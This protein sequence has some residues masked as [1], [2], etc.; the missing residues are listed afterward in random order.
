MSPSRGP[1]AV[2]LLPERLVTVR[3][4][5]TRPFETYPGHAQ[6]T[7]LGCATPERIFLGLMEEI[8]G[9]I[10]DLLE[11]A[12]KA[13]DRVTRG[14]F[15]GKAEKIDA[16]ALQ[17]AL[18][19]AGRQSEMVANCRLSLL[20]L[21]R[22]LGFFDMTHGQGTEAAPLR[23]TVKGLLRDI[24]SL[25]VH[26]DY[27]SG[28]V[29]QV[30]DTTLGMINLAQNNTVKILS[31]VSALFLPP[32]LIASAY[33]MNFRV[34]PELDQAWGYPMAIAMMVGSSVLCWAIFKWKGWM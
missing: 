2:I 22:A 23:T 19:T 29:T 5:F 21:E 13:L 24:Q 34:M 6:Q 27:L 14:I 33:G 16:E 11:G 4:L 32:T 26:G 18:E 7:T 15:S 10:A 28:R 20:T 12:G 17:E 8:V 25:E 9:R 31:V 3:Y 1:A 30:I